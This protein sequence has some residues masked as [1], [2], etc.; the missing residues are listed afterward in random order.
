[1]LK[2]SIFDGSKSLLKYVFDGN[3]IYMYFEKND[4]LR[5]SGHP[6]SL[7]LSI[8]CI[9][10]RQYFSGKGVATL[11]YRNTEEYDNLIASTTILKNHEN[12]IRNSNHIISVQLDKD[13]AK[14]ENYFSKTTYVY[15]DA[16]SEHEIVLMR[17]TMRICTVIS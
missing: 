15:Y 2:L 3:M 10:K 7:T 16:A 13:N 4:Q 9:W 12:E 5:G 17:S 11:Y 6:E 14:L 8:P 1:M